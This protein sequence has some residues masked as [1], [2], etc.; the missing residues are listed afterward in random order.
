[1]S[2]RRMTP[3]RLQRQEWKQPWT[4]R[5]PTEL[6]IVGK[7]FLEIIHQALLHPNL[8]HDALT[9]WESLYRN[10]SATSTAGL[11]RKLAPDQGEFPTAPTADSDGDWDEWVKDIARA[12]G[13]LDSEAQSCSPQKQAELTQ[14]AREHVN[15]LRTEIRACLDTV[16][17]LVQFKTHPT[18]LIDKARTGDLDALEQLLQ[19]NPALED[20]PWV[21]DCLSELVHQRGLSG[22]L[23]WQQAISEGLPV[24]KNKLLEIGCILTLLWFMLCRLTTDQRRGYLKALGLTG[25]PK[26]KS[27]REF[28]RRL[29]LK[30]TMEQ[31]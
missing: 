18:I 1:M 7:V 22:S 24:R 31:Y 8:Q 16:A 11:F 2:A 27:L 3:G 5:V 6:L 4:E 19:I 17:A 15:G 28:E 30:S 13:R 9:D 20:Q 26:K 10:P 21:R 14:Y 12:I 29:D 23:R 25:V